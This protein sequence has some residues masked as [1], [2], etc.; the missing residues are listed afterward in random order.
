[1]WWQKKWIIRKRGFILL[2]KKQGNIIVPYCTYAFWRK[3]N[4]VKMKCATFH[5]VVV[6][7]LLSYLSKPTHM[8]PCNDAN[9]EICWYYR[10]THFWTRKSGLLGGRWTFFGGIFSGS[11]IS[12]TNKLL[13]PTCIQSLLLQQV[14]FAW[15]NF[16][17]SKTYYYSSQV[18]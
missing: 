3:Y 8:F 12:I 6:L 4:I 7:V 15:Y 9:E 13:G 10:S 16:S 5:H 14:N 18:V 11:L 1:M 17:I 2:K